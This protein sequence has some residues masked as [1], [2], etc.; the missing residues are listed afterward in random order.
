MEQTGSAPARGGGQGGEQV[1]AGQVLP[2]AEAGTRY[3]AA[4]EAATA[5]R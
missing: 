4:G 5:G 1:S 3:A 2:V